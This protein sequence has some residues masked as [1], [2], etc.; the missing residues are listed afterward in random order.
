MPDPSKKQGMANSANAKKAGRPP[1]S[2]TKVDGQGTEGDKW[3]SDSPAAGVSTL[4]S[5]AERDAAPAN[6]EGPQ[7]S[8]K[9][10]EGRERHDAYR[11]QG[12]W[13][14][15][16]RAKEKVAASSNDEV[17]S[18]WK[19]RKASWSR[20]DVCEAEEETPQE[21]SGTSWFEGLLGMISRGVASGAGRIASWFG[22]PTGKQQGGRLAEGEDEAEMTS[23]GQ[24]DNP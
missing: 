1:K 3:T 16:P 5:G 14:I 6:I 22:L 21:S 2:L 4:R 18:P 9:K 20:E 8:W 7:V 23:E 10:R 17:D 11:V 15:P 13:S 12:G 19:K 24:R